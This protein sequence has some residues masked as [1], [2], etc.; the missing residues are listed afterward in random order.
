MESIQLIH[1]ALLFG[2][3]LVVAG[4]LSSLVAT[5]F[6]IPLLVVFLAIGMLAGED[7][8]GNI[9]F[10]NYELTYLI[11]SFAL[12]VILFDGGLRTRVSEQIKSRRAPA[13][14]LSTVGVVVTAG[15]V[16]WAATWVLD[17]SL[18]EGFLLGAVVAST[19]AAAVFFLLRT[20]GL[21]LRPHVAS[22]LELESATNDPAAVLITL[23]AT[24]LLLAGPDSLGWGIPLQLA[25]Q[26]GLGAF[27]GV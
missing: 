15:I 25:W 2:A 10:Q 5:R 4:I 3:L 17:L 27:F 13:A 19:D 18:T 12:A 11:G 20:G 6:G 26:V 7:G 22:T 24:N 16:G 21:R 1:Y 23:F 9:D 14:L 8:P